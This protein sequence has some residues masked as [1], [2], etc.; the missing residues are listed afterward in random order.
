MG[1]RLPVSTRASHILDRVS[2][3]PGRPMRSGTLGRGQLGDQGK[4]S[5]PGAGAGIYYNQ[6][7]KGELSLQNLTAPPFSLS[8]GGHR[9]RWR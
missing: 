7:E 1:V 3:W 4:F 2:D 5:V 8:D 9:R 6:V